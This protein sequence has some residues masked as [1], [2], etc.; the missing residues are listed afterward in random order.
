MGARRDLIYIIVRDTTGVGLNLTAANVVVIHDP[1]FN[2]Q[3]DLQAEDRCHRI[4]QTK[5]VNVCKLVSQKT[6]EERMIDIADRKKQLNK[7]LLHKYQAKGTN[8][9]GTSDPAV[10]S[11]LLEMSLELHDGTAEVT[12][13]E[14]LAD[15][16]AAAHPTIA[17]DDATTL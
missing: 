9:K 17:A 13:E 16:K 10:L 2:P 1:D 5:P 12:E 11:A 8:A 14:F 4:G 6:V 15:V 7:D 3:N